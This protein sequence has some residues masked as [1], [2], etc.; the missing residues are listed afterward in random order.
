MV[1]IFNGLWAWLVDLQKWVI[2]SCPP[3]M[4]EENFNNLCETFYFVIE[5]ELQEGK[6]L[7]D[8]D[9]VLG[10]WEPMVYG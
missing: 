1:W 5:F 2:I 4:K 10:F 6:D 9:W 3:L 7:V 8:S